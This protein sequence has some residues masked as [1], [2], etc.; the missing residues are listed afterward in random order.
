MA[1]ATIK[2][3]CYSE[4]TLSG[5]SLFFRYEAFWLSGCPVGLKFFFW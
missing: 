4:A 5:I 3:T 2:G 1:K